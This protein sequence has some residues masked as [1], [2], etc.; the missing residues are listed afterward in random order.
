MIASLPM[1]DRFETYA[2]NDRLWEHFRKF[3][4]KESPLRLSRSLNHWIDWNTPNLL[5]SQSCS[6][7]FRKELR[8]RLAIIGAPYFEIE[9]AAG[10]Y[11]SKIIVR[12]NDTRLNPSE[13]NGARL[14]TNGPDSQS[15]WTAAFEFAHSSAIQFGSVFVS[16]AHVSSAFAIATGQADI[17]AIDALTW[18]MIERWE[19]WATELTVLARTKDTPATPYV[20][21]QK[22]HVEEIYEALLNAI[23]ELSDV[24][25]KTLGLNAVIR[26]Q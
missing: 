13:F 1:Y 24:D 17:A 3:Y 10:Y 9:S 25:R 14:A 23:C 12:A 15:G 21:S 7:P 11:H 5:L 18:S 4:S 8:G 19:P 20:T 16:G 26:A 6:L 2:A 22:E